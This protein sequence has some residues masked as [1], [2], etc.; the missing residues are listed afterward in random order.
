LRNRL[1]FW[2]RAWIWR[3]HTRAWLARLVQADLAPLWT[4]HPRLATKLQRPYICA[5]WPVPVRLAALLG[6]YDLFARLFAPEACL[7]IF[8]DGIRLVHLTNLDPDVQLDVQLIYRDQFE[9]EGELTLAVLDV[10]TGLRLAGITFSLVRNGG[11][12]LMVIGGLQSNP[13]PRTRELIH[14]AAKAMHGLRP[15]A[16]A[17]WCLQQLTAPWQIAQIQ[18]VGDQQH[19]YRHR[20]KRRV[21]PTCY[22]EF[23]RECGGRE[24]PG[25]GSWEL[26]LQFRPRSREE[27]KPSRRKAYER[28][29]LMLD[30][31]RPTLLGAFAALAPGGQAA[32]ALA[33]GPVEFDC[34]VRENASEPP[35]APDLANGISATKCG[36]DLFATRSS[37]KPREFDERILTGARSVSREATRGKR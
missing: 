5:A 6:H 12:C 33:A 31:L 34:S 11:Q 17:F 24:L 26:A 16:L 23:W 28:R 4:A 9:K 3:R 1:K 18:A 35:T 2:L 19:I 37:Q 36:P 20:H 22:D 8:R 7:A 32:A 14:D 29:Y 15:K 25:G 27:L 13:D 30:A 10:A 21:I